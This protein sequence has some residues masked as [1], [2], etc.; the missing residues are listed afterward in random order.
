VGIGTGDGESSCLAAAIWDGQDLFLGGNATTIAGVGYPGSMRKLNAATGDPIWETGLPGNILGSPALNR[1][2][3][4]AAATFAFGIQN[5]TYLIN[6]D[7]G[8]ILKFIPGPMQF[9]QPVFADRYLLL[10]SQVGVLS[11]YRTAR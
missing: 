8:S 9:A 2:G 3:V 11:A 5:G 10:A 4:L 7:D 1:S 6:S